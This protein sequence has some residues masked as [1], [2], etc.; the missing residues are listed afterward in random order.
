MM[1]AGKTTVGLSLARRTGGRYVDNDELLV[2]ATGHTAREL[3]ATGGDASLRAGEAAVVDLAL[4]LPA[5]VIVGIAAGVVLDPADRGRLRAGGHV[6]W[7]R[8]GPATLVPRL[9]PGSHRPFMEGDLRGWVERTV[10]E[11]EPLYREV[12]HSIVDVDDRSADQVAEDIL[13]ALQSD[14]VRTGVAP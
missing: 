1:G 8:A 5:P 4:Q 13:A 3:R 14:D 9:G 10:V 2:L 6:V 11:R 12:A 7:L